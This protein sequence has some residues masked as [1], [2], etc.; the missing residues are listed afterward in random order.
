LTIKSL[1]DCDEG[2][3]FFLSHPYTHPDRALMRYRMIWMDQYA[4]ALMN[5]GLSVYSPVAH[6]L[7]GIEDWIEGENVP[8]F[9]LYRE[10]NY[11]FLMQ[12]DAMIVCRLPFWRE[13]PGVKDEVRFILENCPDTPIFSIDL[14]AME[15]TP[16]EVEASNDNILKWALGGK[17]KD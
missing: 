15:I 12:C 1:Y 17:A 5:A 9:E 3:F 16:T 11:G 4:A 7:G 6:N 14:Y 8:E 10:Q 2:G 13:S